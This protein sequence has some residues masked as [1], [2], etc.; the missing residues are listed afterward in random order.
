MNNHVA[1]VGGGLAGAEAA[2]QAGSRGVHVRL[3]EMRPIRKTPVHRTDLLAELVCSNSLKS[4]LLTTASGL[5]KQ[6]MRILNSVVV[7]CADT[8]C[9]PAG[10][11]LAVDRERFAQ[12]VTQR[13]LALPHVELIREEVSDIPEG[14]SILASGPLTSESLSAAIA[15]FTGRKH[16]HFYDAVAPTVFYDSIDLDR[17]FMASRYDKGDKDYINCPMTEEEYN[18]FWEAL[19]NAERVPIPDFEPM[20]L[21]EGCLPIEELASRG[22]QTL[23]FGPLKPVGLRDPRTGKQPFAVAQ[24]RQ[25]NAEGTLWGLVGFQTR[26]KWKEQERVFRMIPGLEHCR[27]ARF[28]VMHRNTYIESPVLLTQTLE[29]SREKVQQLKKNECADLDFN[30]NKVSHLFFAGQITGVEGYVE[31]AAMGLVAGINAALIVLG[32]EPVA[33]PRETMI[34]SLVHYIT[35]PH[36]A[37]FQPMNANFGLLPE[38]P[39][40]IRNKR[41]YHARQV[42]TALNAM[43]EFAESLV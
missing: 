10:E 37:D 13:V 9:L 7:A 39:K 40:R 29:F 4:N 5:L 23:L 8:H 2:W 24:L 20:N 31:S 36:T 15:R 1:I 30:R 3:F 18:A 25:E 21:F 22:K 11:A 38:L 34:G 43:R 16:L 14:I 35:N 19:V 6:E 33:F 28:G 41:D 26:L 32:K 17:V 12:C 27:F 42:E